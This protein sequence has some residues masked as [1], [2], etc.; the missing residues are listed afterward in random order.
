M[1]PQ[2][3][4]QDH[5]QRR[6]SLAE[7]EMRANE[8]EESY[9]DIEAELNETKAMLEEEKQE[10]R[11]LT[12]KLRMLEQ[13]RESLTEQLE[14]EEVAR[15]ALERQMTQVKDQYSEAKWQADH[16]ATAIFTIEEKNKKNAKEIDELEQKIRE[17]QV[18]N[19]KLDK[20]KRKLSTELEDVTHE[21]D[22]QRNKVL[23]LE[24]NPLQPCPM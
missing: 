18:A 2:Q 22:T 5:D 7:A 13:E 20:N 21:L 11:G 6:S 10:K 24:K 23:E 16:V 1:K 12:S 14:E 19:E 17:L 15:K 4:F 9:L 3:L 8:A